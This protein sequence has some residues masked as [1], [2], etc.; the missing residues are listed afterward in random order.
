MG[1]ASALCG[2]T[3]LWPRGSVPVADLDVARLGVAGAGLEERLQAHQEDRPLGAAVVHELAGLLPADVAE[4][5]DGEVVVLLD[6]PVHRR[7]DPLGR[8]VDNSPYDA[9]RWLQLEDL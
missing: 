2:Y 9:L 5:D 1:P 7:P 4:Q 8:A 6:L 3:N